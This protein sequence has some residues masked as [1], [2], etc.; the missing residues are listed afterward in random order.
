MMTAQSFIESAMAR[1][2]AERQQAGA[3]GLDNPVV[4]THGRLIQTIGTLHLYE[5]FVP[6]ETAF[7][8]DLPLS[9]VPSDDIEPTEGIVLRQTGNSVTIQ[10]FDALGASVPST[11]LIPD[12]AGQLGTAAAR[13]KEMVTKTDAYHLGPSERLASLLRMPEAH[14]QAAP[15]PSS[16]LTTLWSEDRSQR[17]QKLATLAV[18]LIRANKYILVLSPDHQE[19]DDITGLIA[20]SMKAGG[21]NYKTWISRYEM[22]VTS[23][24]GGINLSE[25]GFEAQMHQFYAKSRAEKASLRRKYERFREL[26]PYLAQKGQKKKDL[27]EVRILEWR[28]T[29]ELSGLR[30]KMGEIEDTL[31][32]YEN[33]PLLRRLAMQAAGKNVESMREYQGIYQEQIDDLIKEITIAKERIR[34]LVPEAAIPRDLRPEYDELKEN[35]AKLGGTKKI[36]E[37]LAAEEN[38][39]RQAFLQNRRLVTA[40]PARV[41]SDPLF[42]LVRFDVLIADEAPRI[43]LPSLLAAAGLVRERIII[44][45]DQKEIASSG[46]WAMGEEAVR[47]T[48]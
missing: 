42:R 40:T 21:L 46:C 17:R 30:E 7:S 45:G 23:Q 31:A 25:L 11:T 1:L 16:V 48:P 9:I 15:A 41:A 24:A 19:S 8:V 32:Q 14:G 3:A 34:E 20:R 5:F 35:I 4:A 10:V 26:A 38:T 12:L 37:L 33:L 22:P 44:S 6:P 36:R 18:E 2:E 28:L 13:L 39:N 27:E 43:A 47:T 29:S